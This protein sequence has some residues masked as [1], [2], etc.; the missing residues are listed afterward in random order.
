M[1]TAAR[2]ATTAIASLAS[3]G[4]V[5]IYTLFVGPAATYLD[6]AVLMLLYTA[7]YV[8]GIFGA[9]R[10]LQTPAIQPVRVAQAHRS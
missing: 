5:G 10:L 3:F 9:R 4:A 8:P 7:V 2:L 1:S 6:L